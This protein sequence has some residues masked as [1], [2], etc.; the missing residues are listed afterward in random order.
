[1]LPRLKLT[2]LHCIKVVLPSLLENIHIPINGSLATK[3]IFISVLGISAGNRSI[4]SIEK[5]YHK[6]PCET[7]M[8]YHLNKVTIDQLIELNSKIIL[9]SSLKTLDLSKKY[10]LAIDYTN[11]PYYGKVDV[12]NEK[13]VIRG[14]AKKSTNSFYSYVSLCIIDKNKRLTVSVIPV[15]K[16]S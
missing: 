1:M 4:H 16:A 11:D 15:E 12:T 13:Y 5:Q 14:Q 2:P 10:N 9:Q 8:R 6:T 3:D 7:S